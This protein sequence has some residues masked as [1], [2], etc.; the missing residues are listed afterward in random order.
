MDNECLK[1]ASATN[2][3]VLEM[4]CPKS[5]LTN[6]APEDSGNEEPHGISRMSPSLEMYGVKKRGVAFYNQQIPPPGGLSTLTTSV[7]VTGGNVAQIPATKHL[8][9]REQRQERCTVENGLT[10]ESRV[11][12][13]RGNTGL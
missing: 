13:E 3:G 8:Y 5:T 9:A 2:T 6:R 10:G 7:T 12:E 4:A 11:C 1:T